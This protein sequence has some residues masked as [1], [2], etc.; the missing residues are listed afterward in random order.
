MEHRIDPWLILA[1]VGIIGASLTTLH[2]ISRVVGTNLLL[3]QAIW[4]AIG[5]FV[6]LLL[7]LVRLDIYER[8]APAVYA[9]AMVALV[10]VLVV[11]EARGGNRAWIA[12]GSVTIQPSEFARLATI[13]MGAAWLA[14]RGGGKL[15]LGEIG[16]AFIIVIVPVALI[17]LEPD[18]GVGLT[19]LPVLAGMLILGGLPRAVWITLLVLAIVGVAASWK[20]V[21]QPYQKERVLTV[22]QPERDPFGAGYQVRQSK[23]AVGSGGINGQGLG[24]G[25]QSQLRFLPAQ[26][27]DFAFAVWAEATGF[28]GTTVLMLGYALLLSRIAKVAL[29]SDSRHGL[30]LA[31]LIGGWLVF[32]VIVNLGMVVGW[33]PTA[34]ITLPLFSYGGSSLV[35]TCAALGVVQ[36]VWRHRLVN[37]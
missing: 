28:L 26:H 18:L 24:H 7:S 2:T 29:T 12:I 34:G 6:L 5:L 20:Y 22:L 30:V 9:M 3:R 19:Y 17:W 1:V 14:H 25:S 11:G 8:L 10:L 27:T 33:L 16:V 36:S 35:S 15:R 37:R 23:I 21:L 32:Q 31:A 13:L 4:G